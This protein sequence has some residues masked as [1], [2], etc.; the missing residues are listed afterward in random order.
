MPGINLGKTWGFNSILK[1]PTHNSHFYRVG[2]NLPPQVS[3][4]TKKAGSNR[5]NPN[6]MVTHHCWG[7]KMSMFHFKIS[8][9][10][11]L[12]RFRLKQIKNQEIAH[13][14]YFVSP[15]YFFSQL[16]V[17]AQT[18]RIRS[19]SLLLH[20]ILRFVLKSVHK[21][22]S[23]LLSRTFSAASFLICVV[24]NCWFFLSNYLNALLRFRFWF[25]FQ[26]SWQLP[27]CSKWCSTWIEEE[28]NT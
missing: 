19:C 27:S 18:P 15:Q 9:L 8:I 28:V 6:Y 17:F 3:W 5:V 11:N 10:F 24:N 20:L 25:F 26:I 7:K 21:T 1:P 14:S 16:L 2:A 13:S 4:V 22:D 12:N 23:R